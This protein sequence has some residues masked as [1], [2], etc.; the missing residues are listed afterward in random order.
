M[1]IVPST[2]ANNKKCM[3]GLKSG[4]D[5]DGWKGIKANSCR[6]IS[7][8]VKGWAGIQEESQRLTLSSVEWKETSFV[9][10]GQNVNS[11]KHNF[12][13]QLLNNW[14]ETRF[15]GGASWQFSIFSLFPL[16]SP[17]KSFNTHSKALAVNDFSKTFISRYREKEIVE[18]K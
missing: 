4:D 12:H 6:L 1:F 3:S 8:R 11:S 14:R 10:R 9:E 16:P 7:S 15:S 17:S 13:R 2:I 18:G 5:E